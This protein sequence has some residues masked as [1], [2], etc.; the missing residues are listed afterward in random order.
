MDLFSI[1]A[2]ERIKQ[3]QREKQFDHL[4][5]AGK[6]LP[7]DELASVP[8]NVRMA[9]RIMK[10][11]GYTSEE[12]EI[13]LEMIT[14]KDLIK[15]C[16]TEEAKK[17]LNQELNEKILKYNRLLSKRKINTNSSVFKNYEEKINNKLL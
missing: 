8:E 15:A 9:Y 14:I 2:E 13:K 4:P 3:A 12:S 6:P 1:L 10:N 16:E 11:A 7:K 17:Q 5:G